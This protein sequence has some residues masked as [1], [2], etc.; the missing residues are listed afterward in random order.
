VSVPEGKRLLGIPRRRLT[1]NIK[2]KLR[3]MGSG[4]IWL[5][6]RAVEGS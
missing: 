3:E 2:M 6:I 1:F 4:G 5:M